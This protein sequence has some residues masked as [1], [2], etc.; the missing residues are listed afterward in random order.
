LLSSNNNHLFLIRTVQVLLSSNNNHCFTHFMVSDA[1]L[2]PQNASALL[3]TTTYLFLNR[4][5]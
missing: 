4:A 1:T 3:W 5:E 2:M